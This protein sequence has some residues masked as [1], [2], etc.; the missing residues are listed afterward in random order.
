MPH[1]AVKP[2][3]GV[4]ISDITGIEER[5]ILRRIVTSQPF[6]V[7]VALLVPG[8]AV[9]LSGAFSAEVRAQAPAVDPA[10]TQ[11]LKRM[12]DYLGSLK[13]FSVNTQGTLEDTNAAGHRI[14]LD[15]SARAIVSRPWRLPGSCR[16]PS[17]RSS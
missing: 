16:R 3:G 2:K 11:I 6:W 15:V 1:D 5:T 4:A 7:T 12:T 13:Q 10:A 8:A 17:P 14:D 9:A